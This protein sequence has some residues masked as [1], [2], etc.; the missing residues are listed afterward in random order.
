MIIMFLRFKIT[1]QRYNT[2]SFFYKNNEKKIT[3]DNQ[4]NTKKIVNQL[5]INS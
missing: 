5:S 4:Y 3:S 2:K 1:Q